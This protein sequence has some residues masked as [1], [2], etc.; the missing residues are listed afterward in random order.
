MVIH[1]AMDFV[2]SFSEI[3]AMNST[4][5]LADYQSIVVLALLML[6][7]TIWMMRGKRGKVMQTRTQLLITKN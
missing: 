7:L 3:S 6:V 1:F 5:S 4:V 2:S